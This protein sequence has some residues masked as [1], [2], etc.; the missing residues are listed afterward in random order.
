MA[1]MVLNP[2]EVNGR[3]LVFRAPNVVQVAM[4]HRLR[5]ILAAVGSQLDALDKQGV[6]EDDPRVVAAA[7]DGLES[8]GKVLDLFASLVAPDVNEWLVDQMLTGKIDEEQ[9]LEILTKITPED[10]KAPAAKAPVKKNA[11]RIA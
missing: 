11:K 5:K 10:E 7:S 6:R 8:V 4:L 1:D 9:V 2:V 3:T